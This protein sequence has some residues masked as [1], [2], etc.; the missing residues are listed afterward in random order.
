MFDSAFLTLSIISCF[1]SILSFF[2][3]SGSLGARIGRAFYVLFV[4]VV[5][6]FFSYDQFESKEKNQKLQAQLDLITT[7]EYRAAQVLKNTP[8]SSDGEKRGFIFTSLIFLERNKDIVPDAYSLAR[9]YAVAS[10]VLMN[11]QEDGMKRFHQ[12]LRLADASDAMES[13]LNGLS[14]GRA[15]DQ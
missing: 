2:M 9:E 8:R 12:S 7:I 1:A 10:G 5:I 14:A 13:L 15:Y 4:A 6:A 11:E 3:A